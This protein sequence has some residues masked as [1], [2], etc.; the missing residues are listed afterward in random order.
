MPS[1]FDKKLGHESVRH[2]D[3]PLGKVPRETEIL[4]LIAAGQATR[5]RAGPAHGGNDQ[6]TR[7]ERRDTRPN[8]KHFPQRFMPQDQILRSV[9]RRPVGERT[10]LPVRAADPHFDGANSDLRRRGE[11]G[12]G[13]AKHGHL[14]SG[15]NHPDG[16]HASVFH[17]F[18]ARPPTDSRPRLLRE[19][20]TTIPIIAPLETKNCAAGRP[21][22]TAL[23]TGAEFACK[24]R[25]NHAC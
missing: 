17:S 2:L 25:P 13:L 20:L 21:P 15:R 11:A 5:M 19:L 22:K 7:L 14:A 18:K 4:A 12:L 3:A 6:I 9:W 24:H 23:K 16:S 1:L 10:N 8:L